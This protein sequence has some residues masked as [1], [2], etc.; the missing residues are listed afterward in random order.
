MKVNIGPHRNWIGPYQIAEKLMFWADKYNDDRVHELGEFLA[1]G[2]HKSDP[3]NRRLFDNDR[4]K[5]LLYKFCEWIHSKKER[6]I[7]IKIDRYDSWSAAHTLSMIAL[8]LLKQLAE[9]KHGSPYSDDADVP[10]GLDLRSTEAPPKENEWDTD[11]NIHRRWAWIM[12]EIIWAHEQIV[13]DDWQSQFYAGKMVFDSIPCEDHP[14]MSELVKSD[15][16]TSSVDYEGM[17]KYQER[18]NNG[19]RLFGKYYEHLWD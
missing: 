1:H 9:E 11:G 7:E 6:K 5:T 10:E 8:P 17:K 14:G 2:F 18:I 13:N 16:D 19:M 4:P 3:D 15:D 12:K